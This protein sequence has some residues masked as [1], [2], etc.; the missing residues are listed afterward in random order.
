[1]P[2]PCRAITGTRTTHSPAFKLIFPPR[3]TIRRMRSAPN[4]L[5][6]L[7]LIAD[8]APF[9]A[10]RP[11]P[12][13]RLYADLQRGLGISPS[14]SLAQVDGERHT[15]GNS[16]P[17]ATPAGQSADWDTFFECN[18]SNQWQ[19]APYF[20]G[21]SSDSCDSSHEGLTRYDS[22]AHAL[23]Y[24]NGAAWTQIEPVQ[25]TPVETANPASGYIVMSGNT[26][27]GNLGWTTGAN[28]LCLSDLTTNTGWQGYS[29]ANSR[30]LLNSAHVFAFLCNESTCTSFSALTTYYFANAGNA[31]AGERLSRPTPM[32]MGRTIMPTGRRPTISAVTTIILPIV[33]ETLQHSGPAV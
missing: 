13:P 24:C 2:A 19:R 18:G 11:L 7:I 21:A 3:C 10:N 27:D 23:Y 15:P 14:P 4:S 26:Y 1:M 16:C 32:A 17:S 8:A 29:T 28:A 22:T 25:S 30:G 6:P 5:P 12:A 9:H 33:T 20:F 31:S